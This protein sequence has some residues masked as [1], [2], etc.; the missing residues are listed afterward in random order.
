MK[1]IAF[2]CSEASPSKTLYV[3][4]PK[5]NESKVLVPGSLDLLFNI[6]L[7]GGHANNFHMQNI[8]RNKAEKLVVK[9]VVATVQDTLDY[10]IFKIL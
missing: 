9:Y 8:T 3:S 1:R 2:N 10:S 6:N 5:L 7:E 4:V